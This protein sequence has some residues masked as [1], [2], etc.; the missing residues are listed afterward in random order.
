MSCTRVFRK[1]T[2]LLFCLKLFFI[3]PAEHRQFLQSSTNTH[4]EVQ[5]RDNADKDRFYCCVHF[6]HRFHDLRQRLLGEEADSKLA[7]S[8]SRCRPWVPQGGKSGLSFFKTRDDRFILKEMSKFEVGSIQTFAGNYF[9]Y[10][11]EAERQGEPS[12]LVK[13]KA[14]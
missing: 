6:A 9:D 7:S 13:K 14:P 4:Y 8:L 5:F 11:A 3:I 2:K 10:M 1:A 12:V